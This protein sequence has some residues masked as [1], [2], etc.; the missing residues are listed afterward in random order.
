MV[1]LSVGSSR[2]V[3]PCSACR[4]GFTH[5][6]PLVAEQPQGCVWGGTWPHTLG[7]R[8]SLA[9]ENIREL[10][11]AAGVA[12]ESGLSWDGDSGAC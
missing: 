12:L 3:F 7:E 6:P 8:S 10:D 4:L 5:S 9:D 11:P 2:V 1:T